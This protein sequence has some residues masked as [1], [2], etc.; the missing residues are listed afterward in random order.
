[1]AFALLISKKG[2]VPVD[3]LRSARELA[4]FSIGATDGDIGQV[5]EFYFDEEQWTIR[6]IVV[7]TGGWLHARK[8]L[9]S[10]LSVD[11]VHWNGGQITTDLTRQEVKASPAIDSGRAISRQ[12]EAAY[13]DHH[14]LPSYWEGPALWGP[15]HLPRES[16]T[17]GRSKVETAGATGRTPSADHLRSTE[18]IRG[19][20]IAATDGDIGHV[21]DSIIDEE[22][23]TIRYLVVDTRNWWPGKKVTV[24]PQWIESIDWKRRKVRID[25]P[26]Q[27]IKDSPEY[28]DSM[29][30]DRDYEERLHEHYGQSG[31][32]HQQS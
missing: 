32:W 31:Y 27:A 7:N 14:K 20:S 13:N 19:H 4:N 24:S 6:Y 15:A 5:E 25:Q 9:I 11:G 3:M 1:M 18:D 16:K 12:H 26:R 28:D 21:E 17:H 30:I 23:W 10:P 8:V 22:T 2:G 29:I